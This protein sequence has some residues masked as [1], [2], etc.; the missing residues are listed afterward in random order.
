MPP[1]ITVAPGPKLRPGEVAIWERHADHPDGEIFLA[2]GNEPIQAART[3]LVSERMSKGR[4]TEVEPP[5]K[6]GTKE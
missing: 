1:I 5:A 2:E 3:P 4:L 6:R